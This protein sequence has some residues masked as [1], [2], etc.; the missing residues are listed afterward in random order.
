MMM[1][2]LEITQ[3]VARQMDIE[4]CILGYACRIAQTAS[5]S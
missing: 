5:K 1:T 4:S 3:A 2:V